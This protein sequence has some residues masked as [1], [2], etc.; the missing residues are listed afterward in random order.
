M[1]A[2]PHILGAFSTVGF[3]SGAGLAATAV[4]EGRAALACFAGVMVGLC[5][6]PLAVVLVTS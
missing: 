5:A 4:A 6:V 3:V 1:S 2:T